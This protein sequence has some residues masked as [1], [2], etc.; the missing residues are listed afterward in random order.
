M[1]RLE[2]PT[3]VDPRSEKLVL[4]C[5]YDLS[6]NELYSVNW[7][8]YDKMLFRYMP[9]LT[10]KGTAYTQHSDDVAVDVDKSNGRQLTLVSRQ[11]YRKSTFETIIITTTYWTLNDTSTIPKFHDKTS[12][13]IQK[14]KMSL[15]LFVS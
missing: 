14:D 8:K 12:E 10:P 1:R 11:D 15:P 13:F 4:G 3:V 9:S 2:A 7:Y 6:G 5:D